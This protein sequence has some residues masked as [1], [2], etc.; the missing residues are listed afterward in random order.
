MRR[1]PFRAFLVL[2]GLAAVALVGRSALAQQSFDLLIRGG[3]VVDGTGAAARAADVGIRGERIAAIGDL[4]GATATQ[5]LDAK[6]LVVAPGFVDVH[7][8]VDSE[9]A[10]LPGCDN[11]AR[12]GVTTIVTGNCGGSVKDLRAHLLRV[13]QGGVGINY[14]SLF[15]AGTARQEVLGTQ[16]RAPTAAELQRMQDLVSSAMRAGAF[17]L[18]SGLIY[19]PGTYAQTD[20]L[21]ALA[22]AAGKFGGLYASHIRNEN[23]DVLKAIGE[24][25]RIGREAGVPVQISHV[26]CTGRANWGRSGEVL[27]ALEQARAA[28]QR[29]TADQYAYDASS[30]GLDVLFPSDALSIGRKEFGERLAGDAAFRAQMRDS[31]RA[32]MARIGFGDFSYARIAHAPGNADLDGLTITEAARRRR[33]NAELDTQAEMAMDLFAQAGGQRVSMIYHTIGEADVERFLA[34]D[35][36]AVAADAG[37][38]PADAEGKPHPRGAGNNVR[39]LG[40]YVR[41]RKVLTLELAVRKMTSLPATIF[42]IADR[43]VLREGAFADV[44]VFDAATVADRATWQEPLLSPVGMRWVLVNGAVAVDGDKVTSVRRGKVLRG[45]GAEPK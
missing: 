15:G 31:L 25:L 41:E 17:G 13:E 34:Q 24:A 30:T 38:R 4:A 10:R 40:R 1:S 14:G 5:V 36:I 37:V 6:G 43:G 2:A 32:T 22:T 26:K 35:W 27:A 19:V 39:V 28:G 7:A 8:H 44:A 16:N 42:G 23:D 45:P 21:I 29:V 9:I 11:Y 33:G 3:Q 12:M 20:E 18:S